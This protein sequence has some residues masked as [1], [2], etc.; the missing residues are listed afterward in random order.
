[1]TCTPGSL[2]VARSRNSYPSI[3]GICTS[4]STSRHW[5]LFTSF[6]ASSGSD[7]GMA[8]Y[9]MSAITADNISSCAGSSSSTHGVNE[10]FGATISTVFDEANPTMPYLMATRVPLPYPPSTCRFLEFPKDRFAF[11]TPWKLLRLWLFGTQK[12][13]PAPALL[14]K[15][16]SSRFELFFESQLLLRF[17]PKMV[18]G[19]PLR[20]SAN[21]SRQK[22]DTLSSGLP[23]PFRAFASHLLP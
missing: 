20:H 9:P 13:V 1:M 3:P 19:F 17:G 2:L 22:E 7:V 8:S 10:D 14:P 23:R 15:G 11:T 4:T 21:A 12:S 16:S 6:S 5:P 18:P